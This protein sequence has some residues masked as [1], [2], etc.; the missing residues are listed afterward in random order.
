MGRSAKFR[1]DVDRE[2]LDV[3]MGYQYVICVEDSDGKLRPIIERKAAGD[4][5]LVFKQES[6]ATEKLYEVHHANMDGIPSAQVVDLAVLA[7][8]RTHHPL[9][10]ENGEWRDMPSPTDEERGSPEFNAIWEAI[11]SWDVNVPDYYE[12][13]CGATGSHVKLILDA[14]PITRAEAIT[15][16]GY[17]SS[18]LASRANAWKGEHPDWFPEPPEWLEIFDRGL[19]AAR[20]DAAKGEPS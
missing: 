3:G 14:L 12:G 16:L 11:K 7:E 17:L 18:E 8:A 6:V 9:A 15:A 20:E 5:V 4:N 19:A 13:Y 1:V 10:R 2:P